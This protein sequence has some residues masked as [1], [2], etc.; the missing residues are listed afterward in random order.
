MTRAIYRKIGATY[1]NIPAQYTTNAT[2]AQYIASTVRVNATTISLGRS[3][4]ALM[5]MGAPTER[6]RFSLFAELPSLIPDRN[7]EWI[8][9]FTRLQ[10]IGGYG[11]LHVVDT[12]FCTHCSGR[13]HPSGLCPYPSIN[14][15][16]DMQLPTVTT[17]SRMDGRP[18]RRSPN[19]RSPVW[20]YAGRGRR[21][22]S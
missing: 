5:P 6:A 22:C 18:A 20:G 19:P 16:A 15:F 8:E 3:T 21:K 4:Q 7:K 1:N 11:P 13:T 9:C 2:R 14:G 10:L 12:F 17:P